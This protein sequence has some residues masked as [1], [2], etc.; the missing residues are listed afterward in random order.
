MKFPQRKSLLLTFAI[1]YFVAVIAATSPNQASA[2]L[3]DDHPFRLTSSTFANDSTL[4]ISAID[5]I[6]ANGV[7]ACSIDGSTGGDRS[8]QLSW[9]NVPEHTRTFVVVAYDITAAF[10]HWGMYNIPATRRGLPENAGVAGSK[11][12]TQVVNDFFV[13][14]EYDGPCPPANVAPD[15]HKYV[16]TVYALDTRLTLQGS[17]NFP[18]S[19]ETLYHALIAAGEHRHILATASLAGLYSTTPN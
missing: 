3:D 10:T 18:P 16:F 15:V 5:N 9:T 7:N 17:A 14:A 2:Q 4:P 13:A 19:A 8:P 6:V 1:A 12:G 11:Y